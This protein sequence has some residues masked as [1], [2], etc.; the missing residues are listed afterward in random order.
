MSIILDLI[1][2][3]I[4][5]FF[6]MVSAK[7]GFV[8]VFVETVGFVAAIIVA[9]TI[10]TPLATATY[11]KIIEPPVISAAVEAAGESAEHE[12]WNALPDFI[13]NNKLNLFG[14]TTNE[15]TQKISENISLGVE[16]AVKTASREI[17]RPIAVKMLGLLY[18]VIL[19]IVLLIVVKFLA[20]LLNRVFSFSVVGKLNR[21]L[22][23]LIGLLKGGVIALVF[24]MLISLIISFTGKGLWIF[25]ADNIN[26][27]Y[28]F[29]FFTEIFSLKF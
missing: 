12:A 5:V 6:I 13:I 3:A 7:K 14:T 23:G 4:I 1:V 24:C 20:K 10:S 25:T 21:T 16:T 18:S 27:S 8:N 19:V 28:I 9:F 26:N 22:G 15:F 11:D 2:I 29:K 17:V